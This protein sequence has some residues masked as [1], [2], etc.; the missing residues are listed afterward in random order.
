MVTTRGT[1]MKQ[2]NILRWPVLLAGLLAATSV[3]AEVYRWTDENGVTHFS[4]TPPPSHQQSE[5][6]DVSAELTSV[7]EAGAGI[8]FDGALNSQAEADAIPPGMAAD[9]V[10]QELAVKRE[11]RKAELAALQAQCNAVRSRLAKLE[12]NRRVYFTND[13]GESERMDDEARASEVQQL[14]DYIARNCP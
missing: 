8:D 9:Q 11:Q 4:E 10:R 14:H 13:E 5:V 1:D 2:G 7:S 3:S 12:P 6:Q